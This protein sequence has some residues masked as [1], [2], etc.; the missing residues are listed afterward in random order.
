MTSRS[1]STYDVTSKMGVAIMTL[2]YFRDAALYAGL[3]VSIRLGSGTR[4]LCG[5]CILEAA[6]FGLACG[7]LGA[8]GFGAG[9]AALDSLV[10]AIA[11]RLFAPAS[12]EG[13]ASWDSG[14]RLVANKETDQ[15]A[16]KP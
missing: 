2:M 10:E 7:A 11:K 5:N 16:N 12:L 1:K 8:G 3:E 4:T 15:G 13:R 6:G 9:A 14:G